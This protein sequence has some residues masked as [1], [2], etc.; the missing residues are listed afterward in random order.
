[1]T[2][3]PNIAIKN[4]APAPIMPN[5]IFPSC[6][7]NM[8]GKISAPSTAYGMFRSTPDTTGGNSLPSRNVSGNHSRNIRS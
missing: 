8:P 3:P 4:A 2:P 1:M 5:R 7:N 6:T